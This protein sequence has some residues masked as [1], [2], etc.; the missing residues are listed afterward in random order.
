MLPSQVAI[1]VDDSHMG[2]GWSTTTRRD[3]ASKSSEKKPP[4][5]FGRA[6]VP[7]DYSKLG[8]SHVAT[9]STLSNGGKGSG[10]FFRTTRSDLRSHHARCGR[11]GAR[12][13]RSDLMSHHTRCGRTGARMW[14]PVRAH[15]SQGEFCAFLRMAKLYVCSLGPAPP[16]LPEHTKS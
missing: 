9:C 7:P 10:L 15:T 2:L 14:W 4:I 16:T 11:T 12:T 1:G 8:H 6:P 3:G 5:F 13:T